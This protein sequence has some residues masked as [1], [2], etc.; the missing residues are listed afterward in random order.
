MFCGCYLAGRA[1]DPD[2]PGRL[3]LEV[4]WEETRGRPRT[5]W[6]DYLSH[7]FWERLGIL[8]QELES[9]AGEEDVWNI[10]LR[11]SG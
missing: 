4:S 9:V 11:I 5:G 7:L 8:Q 6:R 10:L 1:S 2:P 3:P